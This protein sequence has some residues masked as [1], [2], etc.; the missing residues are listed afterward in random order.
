MAHECY[1][2]NALSAAY[3]RAGGAERRCYPENG[4]GVLRVGRGVTLYQ[5]YEGGFGT[6]AK[7]PSTREEGGGKGLFERIH[8]IYMMFSGF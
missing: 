1:I 7:I 6:R 3:R 2:E 5:G 8:R 4:A